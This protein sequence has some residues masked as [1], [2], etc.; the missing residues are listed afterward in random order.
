MRKFIAIAAFALMAAACCGKQEPMSIRVVRSEMQRNPKAAD[1]DGC[2]GK[3]K[4]NYTNGLEM[5]AMLDV[6][7]RYGDESILSYV[8]A[9]FD[10]AVGEDGSI[11]TYKVGEY[12]VDKVCPART[13]LKLW[14]LTGKE[15][16]RLGLETVRE[17]IDSHPRVEEGGFWH[18]KIYPDQMWLDGLYMM[19]PFYAEYT[20]SFAPE[21]QKDSL[22]RDI[23]LHFNLAAKRCFDPATGL[24]RHAWDASHKMF[25][26]DPANGQSKH[27]WG[28]A[29]GWYTMALVETLPSIPEGT[30]GRDEMIGTLQHIVETLPAFADPETGMWY[31]VMDCP[32]REGNYLEATC[33]AMFTYAMLKGVRMGY[34]DAGLGEYARDSYKSLVKTF[35]TTDADG[36]TD[37]NYCCEV[38]GLGGK[39]MRSGDFDYYIH[40]PVRAN[41]PKG[42][43]PLIWAS[44][45]MERK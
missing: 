4:W 42:I 8:D 36:L 9:W 20:A 45:E 32:G 15:K 26:C 1:I 17:Q 29:L 41:D 18:K 44:L 10:E 3:I 22:F 23:C 14:N 25:W 37:L 30:E 12:S 11:K 38:S 40:E 31:Q 39:N 2:Q 13:L 6:Y 34:L 5:Y 43:G 21:E 19:Q 7:E 27:C 24:Y 33:S 28:R 35:V 16:Y